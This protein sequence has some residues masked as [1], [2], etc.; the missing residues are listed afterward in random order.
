M[1]ELVDLSVIS[2]FKPTVVRK[3]SF[4]RLGVFIISHHYDRTLDTNFAFSV[5]SYIVEFY[6]NTGQ[7]YAGGAKIVESVTVCAHKRRAFG[8]TVSVDKIYSDGIKKF[9]YLRTNRRSAAYDFSEIS[10]ES[11]T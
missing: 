3:D 8:Y 5:A 2:G 10:A 7:F 6:I 11:G 4:C 1:S 9:T